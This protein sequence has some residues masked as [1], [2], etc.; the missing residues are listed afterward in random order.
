MCNDATTDD[1]VVS[2]QP[3]ADDAMSGSAHGASAFLV[4]TDRHARGGT[5]HDMIAFTRHEDVDELVAPESEV[6]VDRPG[7]DVFQ[8]GAAFR[9]RGRRDFPRRLLAGGA[10]CTT[11]GKVL[12]TV[13]VRAQQ[14][15][16]RY[17]PERTNQSSRST[18]VSWICP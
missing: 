12:A 3:D 8:E 10:A 1:F 6:G 5:E 4:E 17:P 15:E 11:P 16:S 7:E 14:L 13:L 18:S 2:A 9:H